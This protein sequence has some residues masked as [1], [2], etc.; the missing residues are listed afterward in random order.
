M[1]DTVFQESQPRITWQDGNFHV[2]ATGGLGSIRELEVQPDGT[3]LG[4]LRRWT[5]RGTSNGV[6]WNGATTLL[7]WNRGE[8]FQETLALR[9]GSLAAALPRPRRRVRE[10]SGAAHLGHSE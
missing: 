8:N 6:A 5:N 3:V 7:A 2:F 9:R 1:F 4:E 10:R